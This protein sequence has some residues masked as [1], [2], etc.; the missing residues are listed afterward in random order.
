MDDLGAPAADANGIMKAASL[1][2]TSGGTLLSQLLFIFFGITHCLNIIQI[3]TDTAS[4]TPRNDHQPRKQPAR[5]IV[6][7]YAQKG[8]GHATYFG[9]HPKQEN[10]SVGC[11]SSSESA[12]VHERSYVDRYYVPGYLTPFVYTR[13]RDSFARPQSVTCKYCSSDSDIYNL[14][15]HLV[16]VVNYNPLL[17]AS[18]PTN[19]E[20]EVDVDVVRMLLHGFLFAFSPPYT[21]FSALDGSVQPPIDSESS[22]SS[23]SGE[24]ESY[25]VLLQSLTA[26]VLKV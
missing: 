23:E 25:L 21:S 17:V 20:D 6:V 7:T 16:L 12:N 9:D 10:A 2:S 22:L 19:P 13:Y 18:C 8:E 3:D 5:P 15:L 1:C 14:T 4:T 11:S 24:C 26:Y